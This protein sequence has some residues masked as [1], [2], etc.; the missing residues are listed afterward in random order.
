MPHTHPLV[1][2]WENKGLGVIFSFLTGSDEE[3]FQCKS[4]KNGIEESSFMVG[5]SLTNTDWPRIF[6]VVSGSKYFFGS[7][8]LILEYDPFQFYIFIPHQGETL[9]FQKIY[10]MK[11]PDI[12]NEDL[13]AKK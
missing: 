3:V 12:L 13:L 11:L 4:V 6:H 8:L 7:E 2:R 9:L 10:F 1:G 5:L